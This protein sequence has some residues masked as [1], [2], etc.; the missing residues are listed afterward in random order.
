[1]VSPG[2]VSLL[3]NPSLSGPTNESA[4]MEMP[5]RQMHTPGFT[6]HLKGAVRIATVYIFR[7]VRF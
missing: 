3:A 7:L 6:D 5:I 1:M 2:H 4:G